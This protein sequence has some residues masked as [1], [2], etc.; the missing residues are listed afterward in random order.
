MS[1]GIAD[2]RRDATEYL[3]SHKVFRLFEI[4]GAKLTF[5]KPEDPN[6]FIVSELNK[7]AAM[8]SRGQPVTVFTEQ[9]IEVMFTVF[10]ITNRGYLT[11]PQ[12]S[13]ALAAVGVV[14]PLLLRPAGEKID[15][16]TFVSHVFAE[17]AKNSF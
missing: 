12:Y 13:S 8:A 1:D 5:A 11:Q 17:V 16:K 4:I 7:M 10:D 2:P 6:A 15:K 9:D 3:E 14:T